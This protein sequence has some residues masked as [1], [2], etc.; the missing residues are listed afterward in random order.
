MNILS[1]AHSG[2]RFIRFRD[3]A[4]Y[5]GMD[6]NRFNSLGGLT[7]LGALPSE[8]RFR[9]GVLLYGLMP[10]HIDESVQPGCAVDAHKFGAERRERRP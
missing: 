7:T 9:V 10:P 2:P 3:A 8:P 4:A 1:S 6:T 5:L